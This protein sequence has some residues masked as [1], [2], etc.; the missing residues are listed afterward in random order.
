MAQS[1]LSVAP[2]YI[3]T[4][5]YLFS[6]YR[7]MCSIGRLTRWLEPPFLNIEAGPKYSSD[8]VPPSEFVVAYG[9][10]SFSR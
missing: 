6:A 3:S 2:P 8:D 7:A 4:L 1:C 5:R 9:W 10:F